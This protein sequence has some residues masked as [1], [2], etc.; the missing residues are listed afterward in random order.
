MPR[1]AKLLTGT[2][3]FV[4]ALER[5]RPRSRRRICSGRCARHYEAIEPVAESF[6]DLDPE[7]DARINDVA[8]PSEW[9]GFHRIEKILWVKNTTDG[10]DAV[11]DQAA[12]TT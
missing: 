9:T 11:R 5:R 7:I 12:G 3:E 6:G 4:A 8:E 1:R 2:D 10:T